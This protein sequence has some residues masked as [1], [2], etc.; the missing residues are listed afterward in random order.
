MC[1]NKMV[2]VIVGAGEWSELCKLQW[3][4]PLHKRKAVYAAL[5]YRCIHITAQLSNVTER[6]IK[7]MCLTYLM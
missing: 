5:N 1:G 3:V 6:I 4:V 7:G 2:E